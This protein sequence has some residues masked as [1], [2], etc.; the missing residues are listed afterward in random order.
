MNIQGRKI[1]ITG[2]G[3]HALEKLEKL[4]PYGAEIFVI[5]E[6]IS[7]EIRD[8]AE[9]HPEQVHLLHRKL[10]NTDLDELPF[11][12]IAAGEKREESRRIS[13][14]CRKRRIPVN[15]VDDQEFCD[16]IFPSLILRGNLSV[17]ICT[18][19][20]SPGTGVLLKRKMEEQIPEHIEE[21]LDWLQEKRPVL[22]AEIPDKK[23]RFQFYYEL[24]ELCMK[25]DRPLTE[26]EFQERET[27]Y[28]PCGDVIT[29]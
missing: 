22:M 27:K 4:T 5:D 24:S 6:E 17:G 16:F 12:V 2:G 3:K 10:L 25:L 26:E 29:L 7:A 1:I 13:E 23:R 20:A 18:N 21:I 14:Q 28:V 8:F 15:V 11:C 19:G 9:S